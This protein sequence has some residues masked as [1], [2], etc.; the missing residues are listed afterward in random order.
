MIKV[1]FRQKIKEINQDNQAFTLIEM[2]LS[3]AIIAIVTGA[4]ISVARMSDTHKN[5]TLSSSEFKAALREAQTKALAGRTGEE[6]AD[7]HVCGYG[8]SVTEGNEYRSFY[9]YVNF[10]EMRDNPEICIDRKGRRIGES[11]RVILKSESA[12]LKLREGVEFTEEAKVFFLS[13]YGEANSFNFYDPNV[14]GSVMPVSF[15]LKRK[16]D[17]SSIIIRV[18][19]FG[20]ME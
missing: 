6:P 7:V 2:M 3:L 16:T 12:P 18:N 19:Q 5:L 8:I 10:N 20:K 14:D 13:P 15:T 4:V 9:T 11:D 1:F 17:N